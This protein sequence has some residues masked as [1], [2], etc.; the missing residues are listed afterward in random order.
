[1]DSPTRR[2]QY[3][4][5]DE[6]SA[7][8][9]QQGM[10]T[11][12]PIDNAML[13][14]RVRLWSMH[15]NDLAAKNRQLERTVHRLR[16]EL[17]DQTALIRPHVFH[18][19]PSTNQLLDQD[20][21]A[22]Q[23]GSTVRASDHDTDDDFNDDNGVTMLIDA[24][25]EAIEGPSGTGSGH[26]SLEDQ[27]MLQH[28]TRVVNAAH[29]A[30]DPEGVEAALAEIWIEPTAPT[31]ASDSKSGS[32]ANAAAVSSVAG[33]AAGTSAP[34][35]DWPGPVWGDAPTGTDGIG[36]GTTPSHSSVLPEIPALSHAQATEVVTLSGAVRAEAALDAQ[37]DEDEDDDDDEDDL[38][39]LSNDGDSA[40]YDLSVSEE[41]E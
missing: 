3:S 27:V 4:H 26:M 9:R 21:S 22:A 12:E 17:S 24:T 39:L 32:V 31:R 20:G 35:A 30:K 2:L 5:I 11:A 16:V 41:D 34:P 7:H 36:S 15:A 13:R 28:V 6:G 37:D 23:S 19:T 18:T 10:N 40:D 1:M 25:P 14:A 33:G 29:A 38:S 8:S